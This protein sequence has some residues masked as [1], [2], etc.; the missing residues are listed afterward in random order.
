MNMSENIYFL[1]KSN[2]M[3]AAQPKDCGAEKSCNADTRQEL[4]I[5]ITS[6]SFGHIYCIV[7]MIYTQ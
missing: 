6:I 4:T 5:S 2:S 1:T 3:K 7:D